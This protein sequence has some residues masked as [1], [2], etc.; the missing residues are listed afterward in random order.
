M[1]FEDEI[2][3]LLFSSVLMFVSYAIFQ[4]SFYGSLVLPIITVVGLIPHYMEH[5]VLIS[6][7]TASMVW[8]SPGA[9]FILIA[10]GIFGIILVNII[11]WFTIRFVLRPKLYPVHS[12]QSKGKKKS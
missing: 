6:T 2:I 1:Y 12:I 9:P 7:L 5:A 10:G 11:D 3:T 4:V 8:L